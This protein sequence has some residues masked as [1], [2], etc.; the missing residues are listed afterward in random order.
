[1]FNEQSCAGS[2]AIM[3]DNLRQ[4]ALTLW[5]EQ[6]ADLAARTNITKSRAIY[7]A[8]RDPIGRSRH[9]KTFEEAREGACRY[10]SGTLFRAQVFVGEPHD[11]GEVRLL[12]FRSSGCQARQ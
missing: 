7:L 9:R 10:V 5:N 6:V 11:T 12:R 1:M 8:L 2:G 4:A 3:D